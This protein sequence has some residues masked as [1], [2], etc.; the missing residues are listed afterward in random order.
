MTSL[1][2]SFTAV[3]GPVQSWRFRRSLGIDPIGPRSVCSFNCAYCQLGE[4]EQACSER[5]IFIPTAQIQQ[6]L[7]TNAR[8]NN[9]DMITLSGSG[10][11]TLVLNLGEIITM[12]QN[13]TQKPVA[14][15]TNGTPFPL[16]K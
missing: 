2:T 13:L 3:Y 8:W 5:Q 6:E 7:V 11:P 1:K 12:I 16:K 14:V 10:K 15:L 4:I 9:V